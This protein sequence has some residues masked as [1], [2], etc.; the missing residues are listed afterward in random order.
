MIDVEF[1]RKTK[2]RTGIGTKRNHD[3]DKERSRNAIDIP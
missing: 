3:E 1:R 2:K